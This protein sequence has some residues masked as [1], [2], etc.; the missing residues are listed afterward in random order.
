MVY[1]AAINACQL[2][3]QYLGFSE[4]TGLRDTWLGPMATRL[5]RPTASIQARKL[6]HTPDVCCST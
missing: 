4:G 1:S 3:V 2:G 5:E 6:Q